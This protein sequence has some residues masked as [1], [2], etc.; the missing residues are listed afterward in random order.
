MKIIQNFFNTIKL[1]NTKTKSDPVA[2]NLDEGQTIYFKRGKM[3]KVYP[4]DEE[5]W[6]D[7]RYLVSDDVLY[8]LENIS[9]IKK[10]PVPKFDKSDDMMSGYGVTGSLDYVLR[11]K[12]G[13][14]YNRSEKE[15]C[16]ACL[17]KSTE[18]MFSS[19]IGWKKEDYMRIVYWHNEL[20][21]FD[22]AKKAEKYLY[23]HAIFKENPFDLSAKESLEYIERDLKRF[24]CDL[25]IVHDYGSGC[26]EQ[27]AKMRSRIY[28]FSGKNKKYPELPKYAREHGNFHPGCRCT[29]SLFFENIDNEIYYKGERINADKVRNRPFYDDRDEREKK[30]YQEFLQRQKDNEQD[31]INRINKSIEKGVCKIEYDSI[32]LRIPELAPKSLQ[33][34]IRMKTSKSK[35]FMKL[36]TIAKEKGINIKID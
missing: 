36:Y 22:D 18:L 5:S 33:A 3:Y 24:K 10:I 27:C 12:A 13:K 30:L 25:V 32:V 21:M 26:C 31:I 20:G 16:S 35:N 11:M 34:Y 15:L 19:G 1:E 9:D 6:Y 23:N 2:I 8:D 17:W 7:A 28:S 14:F 4:T 29:L